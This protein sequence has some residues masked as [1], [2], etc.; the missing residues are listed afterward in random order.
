MQYLSTC[1]QLL[2]TTKCKGAKKEAERSREEEKDR[3]RSDVPAERLR[4]NHLPV[5]RC[6]CC[7]VDAIV[8][9]CVCVCAI[10]TVWQLKEI[11]HP[12]AGLH[13]PHAATQSKW[14]EQRSN[15]RMDGVR[16]VETCGMM[17]GRKEG[18]R[19]GRPTIHAHLF[20]PLHFLPSALQLSPLPALQFTHLSNYCSFL[21]T[22]SLSAASSELM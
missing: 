6:F 20:P 5:I 1:N 19:W 14:A 3:W 22:P 16:E 21:S 2:F 8:P 18:E 17:I 12:P 9:P 15:G 4:E 10:V 7:I 13:F 11:L